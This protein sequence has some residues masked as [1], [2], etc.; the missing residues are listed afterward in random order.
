MTPEQYIQLMQDPRFAFGFT[1]LAIWSVIWKGL[2]LWR[3][4][5]NCQKIWFIALLV[6]NTVGILEILYL[7]LFSKSGKK[8]LPANP[9]Q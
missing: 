3:A 6:V 9:P 4:S 5:R 7:F 2:A 1:L 8:N